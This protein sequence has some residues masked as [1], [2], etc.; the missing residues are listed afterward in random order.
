MAY[1][2]RGRRQAPLL[3]A[4]SI[5]AT[6]GLVA[7]LL[8]DSYWFSGLCFLIS[9]IGFA[10]VYP[11]TVVMAGQ[12]FAKDQGLAIGTIATG[13]GIGAFLFPFAMSALAANTGI[14]Q[15]F[16][17]YVAIS[18]AMTLMAGLA[19]RKDPRTDAES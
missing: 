8:A 13:G 1:G 3:A 2:Y 14:G 9:G 5:L 18:L 4:T 15:A 19:L 12:Y 16:W 17:F 6:G 11:V 7:A 10:A